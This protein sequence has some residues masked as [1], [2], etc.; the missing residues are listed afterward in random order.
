VFRGTLAI[1]GLVLT[2]RQLRSDAWVRLDHD[3]YADSRLEPDHELACRAAALRLPPEAA[4]AGRSAASLLG[5]AHAAGPGDAVHVVVPSHVPFASRRRV[6]VHHV[7]LEPMDVERDYGLPRTSPVR[8]V[9]DL[10]T[11]LDPTSSVPIID[12]LLGIGVVDRTT[13]QQYIAGR[14]AWRGRRKTQQALALADEG[15]HSAPESALRVRLVLAG[16]P[17]P[18]VQCPVRIGS[19]TLHPDLAWPEYLVAM[20]YD[21]VWHADAEQLHRDRRRLN[22]LAA[23]GW[24]VLHATSDRLRRDFGGLLRETRTALSSRGWRG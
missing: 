11:W 21:G 5:V 13:I 1:D 18:V 20:E 3:V 8:T 23:A 19:V 14:Q 22:M 16:L 12:S 24:I 4:F 6:V 10:A 15:A 2:A 17:R 9:W 7:D